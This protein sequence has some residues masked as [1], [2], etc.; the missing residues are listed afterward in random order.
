MPEHARPK[1]K[2]LAEKLRAIRQGMGISQAEM[3][4]VLK[5]ASARVCEY[6]GDVRQPSVLT[7]LSYAR[8]AGISVEQIMDDALTLGEIKT[9]KKGTSK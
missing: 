7:I 5:L 4:R 9:T 1:P 2:Y 6:E 8:A 3:A